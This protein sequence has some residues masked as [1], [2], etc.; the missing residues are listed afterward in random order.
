LADQP[1]QLPVTVEFRDAL[2]KAY[3]EK[4][5]LPVSVIDT[6]TAKQLG[7]TKSPVWFY[8]VI[9]IVILLIIYFVRKRMK[10]RKVLKP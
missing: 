1:L 6:A 2:N 8:P 7:L 4:I 3:T 9:V 10:K 5:M